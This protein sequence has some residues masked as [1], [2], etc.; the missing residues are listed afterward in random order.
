VLTVP[1]YD[2]SPRSVQIARPDGQGGIEFDGEPEYHGDPASGGVL[3]YHHFGWD[4]LDAMRD[5]GCSDAQACRVQDLER[6]L[7]QGL[8]VLRATR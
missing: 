7:P 6:G 4:L 1:F 3:C 2:D 8:W 5:A